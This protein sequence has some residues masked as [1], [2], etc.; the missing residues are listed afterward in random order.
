MKNFFLDAIIEKAKGGEG[1][2]RTSL[3]QN[4]LQFNYIILKPKDFK[5][6][7]VQAIHNFLKERTTLKPS[8]DKR[9]TDREIHCIQDILEVL[10]IPIR[11]KRGGYDL[12]EKDKIKIIRHWLNKDVKDLKEVSNSLSME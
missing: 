3:I 12:I 10:S 2:W 11:D 5:Y 9:T 6:L 7:T 8:K 1:D 4:F